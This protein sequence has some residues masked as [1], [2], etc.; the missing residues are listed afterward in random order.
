MFNLPK[1]QLFNDF[2]NKHLKLGLKVEKVIDGYVA[3]FANG[4]YRYKTGTDV[5]VKKFTQTIS[6]G[7]VQ[8]LIISEEIF[9]IKRDT[10]K[11]IVTNEQGGAELT[12]SC[13]GEP[14]ALVA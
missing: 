3:K 6:Y 9:K 8:E 11:V 5:I 14:V 1:E 13:K 2:I 4:S 12:I 10:G 7:Y